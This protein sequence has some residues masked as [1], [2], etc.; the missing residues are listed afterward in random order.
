MTESIT[1]RMDWNDPDRSSAIKIFHQQCELYFS[2]KN[3]VETKQV[4]HVL[5]F[6]G[7]TGLKLYNSWG[8]SE[9]NKKDPAVVWSKFE[10]QLQPKTNFRVARLYLQ[11]FVQQERETANDFMSRLKLH[12]YTCDFR[13]DMEF[14]ERVIEQFIAG[15]RYTDI[16]K[17]LLGKDKSLTLENA[18]EIARTYEASQTHM[19]QL[20]R[21][22]PD[23][24]AVDAIAA[25]PQQSACQSCGRHHPRQPRHICPAFGTACK[26]CGKQN[27]WQKFCRSWSVSKQPA[28]RP[29][30][31]DPPRQRQ[32]SYR[33]Q[34]HQRV[35]TIDDTTHTAQLEEVFDALSFEEIVVSNISAVDKDDRSDSA[36]TYVEI[37]FEGQRTARIR[38][39]VDTGAEGNTLPV[40]MFRGMYPNHLTADGFPEPSFVRN[41]NAKLTAYNGTQIKHYGSIVLP[42]R[43]NNS[44]W[45]TD[46]FYVVESEGPAIIGLKTSVQLKLVTMHTNISNIKRTTST[47]LNSTE[48]LIRQYPRQFDHIGEFEGECHITLKSDIQPVIHAPRRCPIHIRDELKR[49]LDSMEAQGVIAKVTEPTQWV[50]SMVIARKGNGSLRVC[51]DPKELNQAIQRCHYRTITTEEI[52]HKL[53]GSRYFSKLDAKSGYWSI[54]LDQESSFLTTFNSPFGRYRYTR[55]PF[56]LSVSQDFFQQRMDQILEGCSGV[57]GI[58]DDI[59]V[60]GATE[61]EHARNLHGLM[62]VASERG[63]QFNSQK[64]LIKAPRIEF[65]GQ[66]YDAQGVHP[67]PKKVDSIKSMAPPENKTQLREFLGW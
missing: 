59:I 46:V 11:K 44:P 21:M 24:K 53:A 51:L 43:Y 48:E 55:M 22:Q 41:T 18:L 20:A 63:L 28:N 29:T 8:L 62:R 1:P 42:C 14:Q 10:S 50:N 3:V 23:N 6:A 54:K 37:K 52:T 66:V 25:R 60:F 2:V 27:H 9:E 65:F 12:A 49:E 16:Q 57:I 35:D 32:N 30:R 47:D 13:D 4:D 15:T 40:R 17:D 34:Q 38:S 26:K 67:D 58:A 7:A 56:G 33:N 64:C 45:S 5:L 36:M 39:K 19:A 61:A 31:R